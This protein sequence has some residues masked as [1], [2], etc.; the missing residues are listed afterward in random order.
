MENNEDQTIIVEN[1]PAGRRRLLPLV[2]VI[3]GAVFALGLL[4]GRMGETWFARS[5]SASPPPAAAQTTGEP[6][7]AE[8]AA[9]QVL[10]SAEA[11]RRGQIETVEAATRV[12]NQSLEVPGRLAINE[13]NLA[14]AGTFVTGRITRILA[15]IGD[16]VKKGQPLIYL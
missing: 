14:R 1:R 15:T 11:I 13:D 3:M 4:V 6:A 2:G 8:P 12:F 9:N 10:L 5:E 7:E 16:S